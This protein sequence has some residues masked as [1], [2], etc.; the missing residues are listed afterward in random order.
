MVAGAVCD[1]PGA[2]LCG[3]EN[4]G[5]VSFAAADDNRAFRLAAGD[6]EDLLLNNFAAT[7]FFVAGVT[8]GC[9]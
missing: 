2:E 3:G 6:P 8:M 9:L 4:S 5:D 7:G 1:V